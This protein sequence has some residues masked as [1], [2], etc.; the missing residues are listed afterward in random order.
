MRSVDAHLHVPTTAGSYDTLF[1]SVPLQSDEGTKVLGYSLTATHG[2]EKLLAALGDGAGAL[3]DV[4]EEERVM[5]V[6][7]LNFFFVAPN[8]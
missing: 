1:T 5:W 7:P 2:V 4:T 8:G 6:L 3:A